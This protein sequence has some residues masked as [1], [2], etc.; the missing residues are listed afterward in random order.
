MRKHVSSSTRLLLKIYDWSRGK[1]RRNK[2]GGKARL[3]LFLL[4]LGNRS[5]VQC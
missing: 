2:S 3:P 5:A 4:S 1:F